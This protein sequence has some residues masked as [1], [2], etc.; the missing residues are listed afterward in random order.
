MADG[1]PSTLVFL[2]PTIFLAILFVL[3]LLPGS[4]QSIAVYAVSSFFLFFALALSSWGAGAH[5]A[6]DMQK[7]LEYIG[8]LPLPKGKSG[9]FKTAKWAVAAFL[10]SCIMTG[11]VSL[12][13]ASLGIADSALV[14]KKITALPFATLFIAF[15]VSPIAEEA[16]FRGYFFR[17]ISETANGRGKPGAAAAAAGAI[18]SSLIFAI[19]HFSYGSVSEIAVAFF[20]GLA[21]CYVARKSGSIIPAVLAHAAF[22]LISIAFM[23]FL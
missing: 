2:L 4:Q 18:I 9:L 7:G 20:V 21:L 1:K 15:T 12:A 17:K 22:N 8:L 6:F 3:Y 13:L 19:L 16:L 10:L 5:G 23:V 11:A 14:E